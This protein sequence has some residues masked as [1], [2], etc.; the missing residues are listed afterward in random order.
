MANDLDLKID[1]MQAQIDA[2]NRKLIV[3]LTYVAVASSIGVP[4]V[5]FT[6]NR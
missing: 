3:F 2:I 6:W 1:A 5:M 4:W